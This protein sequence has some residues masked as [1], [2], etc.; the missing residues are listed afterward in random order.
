MGL[1]LI[2]ILT[3]ALLL[4]GIVA[5]KAFFQAAQTS[6]VEPAVPPLSSIDGIALVGQFTVAVHALY[7][8]ALRSA[9][10]VGAPGWMAGWPI[11]DPYI[12][13]AAPR[14]SVDTAVSLLLGLVGLCLV[15]W[16]V[17]RIAGWWMMRKADKTLFYGP[18]AEVFAKTG[19]DRDFILAYVVSKIERDGTL[20]GYQGTVV[21]LLR[22]ADRF[23][24][25]VVLKSVS[26]FR[27]VVSEDRPMRRDAGETI[28]WIALSAEQWH[29]IAFKVFR[30][31]DDGGNMGN[32]QTIDAG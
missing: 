9:L 4:P 22:D 8:L 5:A 1:T 16:P 23:P 11:A 13:F 21:S 32:D 27:L 3:A 17:G 7:A 24:V 18:M 30:I 29:N 6:E 15:A 20:I 10:A 2:A 26:V 14:A 19:S 31:V 28:D 12:A 25:K